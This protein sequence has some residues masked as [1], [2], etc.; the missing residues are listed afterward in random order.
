MGLSI[1]GEVIQKGK[2]LW[3]HGPRAGSRDLGI[4]GG[5]I[6]LRWGWLGLTL[7]WVGSD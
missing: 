7:A 2:I 6:R 4:Y 1:S 5:S 3:L